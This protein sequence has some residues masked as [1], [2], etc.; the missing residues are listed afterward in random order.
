MKAAS[1]FASLLRKLILLCALVLL[2]GAAAWGAWRWHSA[3]RGGVS[4]RTERLTGKIAEQ[5]RAKRE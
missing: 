4:Y 5:K 3:T 2:L 1:G